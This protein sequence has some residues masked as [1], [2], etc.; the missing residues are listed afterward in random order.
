MTSVLTAATRHGLLRASLIALLVALAAPAA[1]RAATI[2]SLT[3]DDGYD[4]QYQVRSLLADRG[5]RATFFV[6][7]LLV[8][9]AGRLTWDQLRELA[10]DG[11]EIGGHSQT[12]ARLSTLTPAQQRREICDDRRN[13]L[14]QNVGPA[15]SFAYPFG[16][17]SAQTPSIVRSCGYV[18]ARRNGGIR[19]RGKCPN[20]PWAESIPPYAAFDTRAPDSFQNNMSVEELES[21]VTNAEPRGGWVQIIFHGICEA[22]ATNSISLA[23]LTAFLDW[24]APRAANG[25][26]V[27]RVVDVMGTTLSPAP[28]LQGLRVAPRRLRALRRGGSVVTTGGARVSFLLT[29]PARVAFR[30]ERRLASGRYRTLRGSFSVAGV[31]GTNRFRFSGRLAGRALKRGA[32]RLRARATDYALSRSGT[33]RA[34]F[35]IR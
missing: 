21:Y 4:T 27:R 29:R 19:S 26:V 14:A 6:N 12:H 16:A 32:Y 9:K 24:L 3:F 10:A 25:T 7:S 30:V 13:I 8:G 34:G 1:G 15:V 20:C 28:S 11:N 35:V 31:N 17:F 22:C 18:S 5:M 2:V 33:R 23:K